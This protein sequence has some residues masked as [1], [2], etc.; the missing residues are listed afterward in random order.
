MKIYTVGHSNRSLKELVD[1]LEK[2]CE[3]GYKVFHI[4]DEDRLNEH[5]FIIG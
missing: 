4:Y 2:L 1:I 5:K 3:I